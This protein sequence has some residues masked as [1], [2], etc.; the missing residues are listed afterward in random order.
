METVRGLTQAYYQ[1]PWRKQVKLIALFLL[2]AIFVTLIAGV[3]LSVTARAATTGREIMMMQAEIAR[4]ELLIADQR[5]QL[6]AITSA[7]EMAK[8]AADLGFE[9]IEKG[10]ALY[11]VVPGYVPRGLVRLAP[12]PAPETTVAAAL[13]AVYNESLI[14]WLKER[15]LLVVKPPEERR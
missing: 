13:P 2:F 8:R 10:Q 12:V 9:P 11:V 6:A 15:I 5:T 7:A 4:L 1:A 3:Y 14:D